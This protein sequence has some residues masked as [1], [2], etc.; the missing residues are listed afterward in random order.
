MVGQ[1]LPP[2]PPPLL[3]PPQLAGKAAGAGASWLHGVSG[4]ILSRRATGVG[5]CWPGV[6]PVCSAR[7]STAVA[8]EASMPLPL[9][10][11]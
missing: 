6:H 8:G 10:E 5:L 4:D 11:V 3:L 2:L 9:R 7:G 1:L